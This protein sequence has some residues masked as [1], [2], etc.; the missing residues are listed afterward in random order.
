M[1][2]QSNSEP[3]A[4]THKR[5]NLVKITSAPAHPIPAVKTLAWPF[6]GMLL[7]TKYIPTKSAKS[8]EDL[9]NSYKKY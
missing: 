7:K 5:R 1:Y 9:R 2:F 4:P 3:L 6:P 8:I